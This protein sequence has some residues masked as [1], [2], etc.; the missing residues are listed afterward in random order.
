MSY[1]EMTSGGEISTPEGLK[2]REKG[3]ERP[4]RGQRVQKERREATRQNP[5]P[6]GCVSSP[7][8]HAGLACASRAS[9]A[10]KSALWLS[11]SGQGVFHAP[12]AG[13]RP[14]QSSVQ[15]SGSQPLCTGI[16][17]HA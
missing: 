15:L 16:M 11:L 5:A 1:S 14:G 9:R 13:E 4:V 7:V 10:M 6:L 12:H 17:E 8:L 2:F 3:E